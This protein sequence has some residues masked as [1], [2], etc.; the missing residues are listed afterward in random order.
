MIPIYNENERGNTLDLHN[1]I[2]E[3]AGLLK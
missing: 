2:T 3:K 1:K